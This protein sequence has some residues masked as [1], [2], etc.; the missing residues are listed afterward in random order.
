MP[1]HKL[2]AWIKKNFS[3]QNDPF[4]CRRWDRLISHAAI[5]KEIRTSKKSHKLYCYVE[6]TFANQHAKLINYTLRQAL[7]NLQWDDIAN[8]AGFSRDDK[9]TPMQQA[10]FRTYHTLEYYLRH[11]I[12]QHTSRTARLNAYRRWVDTAAILLSSHCYEGSG[13]VI[14]SL[15]VLNTSLA[16]DDELPE[17]SREKLQKLYAV[18]SPF[19]NFKQLRQTMEK[20][21]SDQDF[22][23]FFLIGKDLTLFDETLEKLKHALTA[24]FQDLTHQIKASHSQFKK[25]LKKPGKAP[26]L[27]DLLAVPAHQM[28]DEYNS[29]RNNYLAMEQERIRFIT[30]I[31]P[32]N[33]GDSSALPPHLQSTYHEME[34]LYRQ[35]G[36]Q[37][38]MAQDPPQSQKTNLY[39]QKLLPGFWRRG[40]CP[41]EAHWNKLFSCPSA[42]TRP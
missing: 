17:I 1:E 9:A 3:H 5:Q 24:S 37:N 20:N 14:A 22:L 12:L 39:S 40:C 26:S 41:P 38:L 33:K 30:K 25:P 19:A 27:A 31:Q 36:L 8:V 42:Q 7:I 18:Y 21:K 23:P 11:D 29:M 6:S 15:S 13:L 35:H 10:Y 34:T 16:L 4:L 28:S 32:Q 2:P